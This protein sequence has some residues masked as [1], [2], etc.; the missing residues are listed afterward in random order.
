MKLSE[1]ELDDLRYLRR[2][3]GW[4]DRDARGVMAAIAESEQGPRYFV[5]LA[6]AHR[7]GYEPAPENDFIRLNTWC[8]EQGFGDPFGPEF[9]LAA[10]QAMGRDLVEMAG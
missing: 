3:Y 6:A 8:V 9:D 10:L 1:S 5:V 2:R 4:D 7:A